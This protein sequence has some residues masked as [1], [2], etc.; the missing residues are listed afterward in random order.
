MTG[1]TISEKILS[2]ACDRRVKAGDYV[3]PV[4]D[5]ITVH[6]WYVAQF[7]AALRELGVE[8]LREPEKVLLSSDHEPL[9]VSLQAAQRQKA[10]RE[11]AARYGIRHFYD[12][13]RGGH[14][15]IFPMERGLVRPGMLVLAYDP[16][17]TNYGAVGCLG[18]SLVIEISEVLATGT[19]WIR[20]PETIRIE[21]SGERR[22]GVTI[23]DVAQ[24]LIADLGADLVD[25]CTVEFGGS[26][27]DAI[28][29]DQRMTLC[30]TPVELGAKS[31][32]VEP[33][34]VVEAWLASRV[35]GGIEPV[36][37]DPDA[38]F[39]ATLCYD[40]GLLEPQVAVPPTP[41]R[42]VGVSR[43]A[44]RPVQHAFIGSCA[45]ASL[46]D[47]RDAATILRGHRIS[48][49]V[50]LVV[51]PGTPEIASQAAAEGVLSVFHDAGAMVTPA[52]CGPCAGGRIAPLAPGEVSI[53]TGTRN[54]PGRL[55]ARDAEIYLAS[56]LTVAASAVMGAIAD[57]RDFL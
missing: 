11:I 15:H 37:S 57:P 48:Q 34:E 52:G 41:D 39:K 8:R 54:D 16:H 10:V 19:A 30:N 38:A 26:A 31:V 14:G 50:R 28:G 43:V 12:A 6:D 18:I 2:R 13:G 9:A 33:D 36:G 5:L 3:Y 22:P 17:V 45:N 1:Q 42:V 40:L 35:H 49:G 29:V 20:V 4:P 24:R 7:D 44:G 25:Y 23:R 56:P 51:T 46:S 53:N 55:G 47:L 27:L 32:V 21:L